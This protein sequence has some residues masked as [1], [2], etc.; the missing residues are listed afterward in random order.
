VVIADGLTNDYH[1]HG[2]V[3]YLTD[4]ISGRFST[5]VFGDDSLTLIRARFVASGR[6]QHPADQWGFGPHRSSL[7]A[8]R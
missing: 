7:H 3:A 4:L 1:P 2:L 5:E 8:W 6:W